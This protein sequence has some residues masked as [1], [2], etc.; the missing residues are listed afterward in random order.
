MTDTEVRLMAVVLRVH[1]QRDPVSIYI[2]GYGYHFILVSN[3][4]QDFERYYT[5]RDSRKSHRSRLESNLKSIGG[6]GDVLK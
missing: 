5:G 6:G 2:W 3:A 4:V 1:E